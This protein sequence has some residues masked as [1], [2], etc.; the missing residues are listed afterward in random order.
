MENPHPLAEWI[1]NA[2]ET[3]AAFARRTS[4]SEAHL[5]LILARK[6]GASLDLATRFER[7]TNGEVRAS[8]LATPETVQ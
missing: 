2:G 6:R 3:Q 4:V 7:A 5:S 8:D 1:A